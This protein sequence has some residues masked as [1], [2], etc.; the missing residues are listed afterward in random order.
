MTGLAISAAVSSISCSSVLAVS[1]SAVT[2]RFRPSQ[3][4]VLLTGAAL[5]LS[6]ACGIALTA[7][8]VAVLATVTSVAAEG[9]WS[10]TVVRSA[11]AL[12]GWLGAVAA[13][14]VLVLLLRATWRVARI[15]VALVRAERLCRTIRAGG[16]PVVIVDDDT[17]DA[18]TLAGI[19]GC[20]VIGRRLLDHLTP[21]ERRVVTAHEL[22]HLT[23]RHHVYV[24]LADIA[25]AANPLL[26]GIP[27]AVRVGVERWADEE[28]AAGIGDR[29]IT[30]RALA[31]VALVRSAIARS[32]GTPAAQRSGEVV[33][34][35]GR[36][37][38]AVLGVAHY[39]VAGRVQ[40][41]L[42][43]AKRS[44]AGVVVVAVAL[45]VLMLLLGTASLDRIQDVI[46]SAG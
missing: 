2:R 27:Q 15:A 8:A 19:H 42:Q 25:A 38:G 11:T 7:I 39:A 36:P 34:A 44:H 40:A 26:R 31:R 37:W 17:V 12:P 43:P 35:D 24:H 23:R 21:D 13:A 29:R 45:A 33:P 1:V 30:G 41:L 5:A 22:A 18:Y 32:T 10:A 46:E 20:V 3:A 9:Q 14:A 16:G 6:L 28:A 4:V